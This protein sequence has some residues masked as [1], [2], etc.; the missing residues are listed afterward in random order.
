VSPSEILDRQVPA[1][2]G[3]G[4]PLGPGERGLEGDGGDRQPPSPRE[5]A[6]FGVWL[7]LG[8]LSM[9]FIGFTSAYMVRRIAG[10]WRPLPLPSILWV[11]TLALLA[12]SVVLEAAR[13]ALSAW[14]LHGAQRSLG[15]TGLLGALFAGGQVVAWSRLAAQGVFL[16]SHPHSSFFYMLTGVHLAH[17]AGGLVWFAAVF[18]RLRRLAY[19]PGEDG[20]GLF[21]IYWH[22]VGVLWVYLLLLLYVL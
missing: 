22:F 3:R 1:L 13:R 5:I 7:M 21:A 2:A 4:G 11:N 9:M 20:L 15:L 10:D 17:L 14:D 16:S 18:T 6:R 19:A 8:T 12:S